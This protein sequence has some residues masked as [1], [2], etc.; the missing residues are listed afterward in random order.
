MLDKFYWLRLHTSGQ[1]GKQVTLSIAAEPRH[2]AFVSHFQCLDIVCF[3]LPGALH[4]ETDAET[5]RT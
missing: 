2:N 3:R 4:Q 5:K 1:Q